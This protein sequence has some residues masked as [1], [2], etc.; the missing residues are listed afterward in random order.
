MKFRSFVNVNNVESQVFNW[1]TL[2][3]L[4]EPR[5]TGSTC[6]TTGVVTL[7]PGQGHD[8][9]NHEGSEEV[10]FILEG[11]GEQMVEH[12]DGTQEKRR[13]KPGDLVH[14]GPGQ[15]HSTHNV[16]KNKLRILAVYEFAGPES[17]L[18]AAPDCTLLPPK[19]DTFV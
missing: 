16:G 13:V 5:V 3:W 15:F 1:G 11:E 7:D 4:S 17:A 19:S 10:L 8:R 2:Q 9:H 12:A 14:L 18:R 6:M